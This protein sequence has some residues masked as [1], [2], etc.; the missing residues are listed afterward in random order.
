MTPAALQAILPRTGHL[1][2]G[3]FAPAEP[4][5]Q[6]ASFSQALDV[7]VQALATSDP[8]ADHAVPGDEKLLVNATN[9]RAVEPMV[10]LLAGLQ[11]RE[12]QAAKAQSGADLAQITSGTGPAQFPIDAHEPA[13]AD[14]LLG[15]PPGAS[16]P[17]ALSDAAAASMATADSRASAVPGAFD[18][19]R[20]A[21]QRASLDQSGKSPDGAP[22]HSTGGRA[23]PDLP[24]SAAGAEARRTP[25]PQ[26][27]AG[28][29][30]SA[31]AA[32]D[33]GSS[34]AARSQA[35]LAAAASSRNGLSPAG[36]GSA[37]ED[38]APGQTSAA[39]IA[40][41]LGAAAAPAAA[42][43]RVA[44]GQR[45]ADGRFPQ[46][47]VASAGGLVRGEAA[48]A[49]DV[50]ADLAPFAARRE[51]SPTAPTMSTV[52]VLAAVPAAPGT[53]AVANMPHI[54]PAVGS[55]QWPPALAHHLA[56]L[57]PGR[58]VELNLN[59]EQLGPLKVTLTM[60]DSRAQ[61][62]FTSDHAAVRQALEAALPQLRA[63]FADS[64]ITL[65]QATVGHGGGSF[66]GEARSEHGQ[67]GAH[68][69]P[70]PHAARNH[71][72]T[73][74]DAAAASAGTPAR[75]GGIDTFA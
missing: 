22:A 69:Q 73:V 70:E 60:A 6:A 16:L 33:E 66:A 47:P 40:T 67:R 35:L 44:D 3:R 41:G 8:A 31:A 14:P 2:Q 24:E 10:L 28:G 12:A 72:D 52:A 71:P 7:S 68:G 64:G 18:Q 36:A 43:R 9:E 21:A 46:A 45:S 59:P 34:T 58:E 25:A 38:D 20:G 57:A 75:P 19:G 11:V 62:A 51:L 23:A 49:D 39:S 50:S 30:A 26:L 15:R 5:E 27:Q 1:A 48:S 42:P 54:A 61:L 29:S 63:S 13:E 56:K 4:V 53:V 17:R 55:D 74:A 37:P 32:V 65:G